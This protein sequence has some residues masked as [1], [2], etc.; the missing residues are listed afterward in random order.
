MKLIQ[1]TAFFL[2]VTALSFSFTSCNRD[3]D[4]YVRKEYTKVEVP[5]TGAL[6]FPQSASSALG[7]MNIHYNTTTKILTYSINWTGLSGAVS[8]ANIHGMAPTGYPA[9]AV[10]SLSTSAIVKCATV[11]NT[12]CGSY[13][14]RLFVDGVLITEDNLLNGV[15]YVSIR[16]ASYP[17]GEIRAQ[18][19]F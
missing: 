18:I 3:K 10:Q 16:T 7:S 17:N 11:S 13:S 6:N 2:F 9:A 8:S 5:L 14:G 4:L 1:T 19:K 12:S 15:Y